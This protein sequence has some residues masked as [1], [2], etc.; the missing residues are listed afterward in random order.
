MQNRPTEN[1]ARI[2][3]L[4]RLIDELSAELSQRLNIEEDQNTDNREIRREIQV[5]DTVEITNNYRN[6]LGQRGTVT[7]VTCSQVLLDLHSSGQN[8]CKSKRNV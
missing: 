4:A 3:E 2:T 8:I 6:Q 1:Q 7:H 5:G